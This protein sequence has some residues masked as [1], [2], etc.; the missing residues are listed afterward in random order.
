[1]TQILPDSQ[2]PAEALAREAL[3]A[4]ADETADDPRVNRIICD[5]IGALDGRPCKP[6]WWK[7]PASGDDAFLCEVCRRRLAFDSIGI[8]VLMSIFEG[9]QRRHGDGPADEFRRSYYRATA[10]PDPPQPPKPERR[11]FSEG[12]EESRRRRFGITSTGT[13]SSHTS[14][15]LHKAPKYIIRQEVREVPTP[16]CIVKQEVTES[17]PIRVKRV[18]GGAS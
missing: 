11:S 13:D 16:T 9:F 12:L 8:D 18:D 3:T 17:G 10:R 1:M 5:A 4:L 7:V 2:T 15:R 6:H 14:N